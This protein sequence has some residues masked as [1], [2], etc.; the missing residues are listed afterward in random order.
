MPKTL[1]EF[2]EMMVSCLHQEEFTNTI[3]KT[4]LKTLLAGL[5]QATHLFSANDFET[6]AEEINN[7]HEVKK[8]YLKTRIGELLGWKRQEINDLERKQV[9][10]IPLGKESRLFGVLKKAKCQGATSIF[11]VL[12][13]DPNHRVYRASSKE[14]FPIIDNSVCLFTKEDECQEITKQKKKRKL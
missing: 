13:F 6:K 4:Q 3:K 11:Q 9:W 1:F 12:I 8:E 14:N 10:Q 7:C 5:L 2:S